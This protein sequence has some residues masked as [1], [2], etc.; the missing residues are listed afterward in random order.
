LADSDIDFIV[1]LLHQALVQERISADI[2]VFAGG[3]N[4][5]YPQIRERLSRRID[6]TVLASRAPAGLKSAAPYGLRCQ[7]GRLRAG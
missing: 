5:A 1:R 4:R 3:V 2:M 6:A 7:F